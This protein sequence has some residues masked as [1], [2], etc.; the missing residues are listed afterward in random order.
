MESRSLARCRFHP[1]STSMALD[2]LLAE[3]EAESAPGVLFSVQ[4]L[5]HPEYAVLECRVYTR[6]VVLHREHPFGLFPPG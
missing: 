5:E 4:A 3:C 2:G 6:T 1:D